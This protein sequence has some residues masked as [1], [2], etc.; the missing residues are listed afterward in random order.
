ML[1]SGIRRQ[2]SVASILTVRPQITPFFPEAS[3]LNRI[4]PA[5]ACISIPSLL[6]PQIQNLRHTRVSDGFGSFIKDDK[7]GYTIAGK[8]R[9][10]RNR[11]T[12]ASGLNSEETPCVEGASSALQCIAV[13]CKDPRPVSALRH[14]E[15]LWIN[16]HLSRSLFSSRNDR[17][18]SSSWVSSCLSNLTT[19]NGLYHSKALALGWLQHWSYN[20]N[21]DRLVWVVILHVYILLY[22]LQ[23]LGWKAVFYFQ[24]AQ[25]QMITQCWWGRFSGSLPLA[26]I[27]S[28][29]CVPRPLPPKDPKDWGLQVSE[30]HCRFGGGHHFLPVGRSFC[31]LQSELLLWIRF[32][33]FLK[34]P[35]R[36][37]VKFIILVP[38][39]EPSNRSKCLSFYLGMFHLFIY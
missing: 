37:P 3:L 34:I 15:C 32:A 12:E 11:E 30:W 35:R 4:P 5:D 1:L 22:I 36:N 28:I 27:I 25:M 7:F 29:S 19:Q 23:S 14:W 13:G 18:D 6:Q 33:R 9:E 8:Y 38:G 24:F 20:Q 16:T 21:N 10:R 26:G 2:E 17:E 31:Y 39:S